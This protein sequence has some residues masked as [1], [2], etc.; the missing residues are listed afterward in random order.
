MD[1]NF[2]YIFMLY[3]FYIYLDLVFD[4]DFDLDFD[5]VFD[6]DFDLD[7]DRDIAGFALLDRLRLRLR[8]GLGDRPRLE[9]DDI[10]LTFNT[11]AFR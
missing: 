7:F 8:L 2:E 9:G 11:L 5:R 1:F 6:L 10:E 4:L 3:V